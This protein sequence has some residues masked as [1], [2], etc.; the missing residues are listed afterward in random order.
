[1]KKWKKFILALGLSI[2]LLGITLVAIAVLS[3]VSEQSETGMQDSK[4]V[5]I[6]LDNFNA[7]NFA[8]NASNFITFDGNF[9]NNDYQVILK[10]SKD[11]KASMT[12]HTDNKHTIDYEV[13][14]NTL[15]IKNKGGTHV[16]FLSIKDL[17]EFVNLGKSNKQNRNTITIYIPKRIH[18]T[19]LT[20]TFFGNLSLK[21][22]VVDSINLNISAGNFNTYKT[23]ISNGSLKINAGNTHTEN[24]ELNNLDFNMSMGNTHLEN[25]I[26]TNTSFQLN[27]GNFSA[28]EVTFLKD[29]KVT[30]DMGNIDITLNSYD[31]SVNSSTS[32]GNKNIT[33]ILQPSVD[34]KLNLIDNMGNITLK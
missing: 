24:S 4:N 23:T 20:G 18:L 29:N 8:T 34:N 25:S 32:M 27:M 11:D 13:K 19:S 33:N 14:D 5:T 6:K 7:I 2:S 1:M 15:N 12:Y 16:N 17:V 3:G 26:T 28:N 10:T 30:A 9:R 22:L 31:L 21:N